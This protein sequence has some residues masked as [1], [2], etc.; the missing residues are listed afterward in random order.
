MA[1]RC[2]AALETAS[3]GGESTASP[4]V[5]ERI[6]ARA[7]LF[8]TTYVLRLHGGGG[9]DKHLRTVT[10][11]T[12]TR[13]RSGAGSLVRSVRIDD[14][15]AIRSG[16][17][18][19]N[20]SDGRHHDSDSEESSL[21]AYF[22]VERV[23]KS[24]EI[25][26]DSETETHGLEPRTSG[27][28]SGTCSGSGGVGGSA[29]GPMSRRL[30]AFLV[31][32][33]RF[34]RGYAAAAAGGNTSTLVWT[35]GTGGGTSWSPRYAHAGVVFSDG[36]VVSTG[37]VTS[38][39]VA[40]SGVHTTAAG[41]GGT[42]KPPGTALTLVSQSTFTARWSHGIARVPG[43]D[44]AFLVVAG[45]ATTLKNDAL[46]TS[47]RGANF[48]SK[49]DAVFTSGRYYTA[50]VATA[51]ATFVAYAGGAGSSTFYNEVRQSTNLGSDWTTLR[52]EGGGGGGSCVDAAMWSAR[53]K[54]AYAFMPLQNR[55][56]VAG[57][58]GSGGYN[59]DVWGSD[60]GGT[61]WS[62]LTADSDGTAT[63]GYVGASLVVAT[64]GG[65]EILVLAGGEKQTSTGV[66]RLSSVYRCLDAGMSWDVIASSGSMW[67]A[68]S[69][70]VFVYDLASRRLATMGGFLKGG[71]ANDFWS[72]D[73]SSLFI[74]LL[75]K[76]RHSAV[77][78]PAAHILFSHRSLLRTHLPLPT[79]CSPPTRTPARL[80]ARTQR[81]ATRSAAARTMSSR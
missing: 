49:T 38:G 50:L 53:L 74:P 42:A 78:P 8:I 63:S 59:Q 51:P 48:V 5:R 1:R 25:P 33:A 22:A 13:T 71:L 29:I 43:N 72:A 36:V 52:A 68:R 34:G 3:S 15:P 67:G 66:Q 9:D 69:Y 7:A 60:D 21:P 27:S 76:V 35:E 10:E 61:C 6:G 62:L 73:A 30:F 57:G 56:L 28:S 75:A 46:L 80:P 18:G 65:V 47:D 79:P 17:G 77:L 40:S 31:T 55:I 45:A 19:M 12:T 23:V 37:G 64:L 2:K 11:P 24:G 41:T 32:T 70:S 81:T 39:S 54:I 14:A 44:D 4:T 58:E 16:H 26:S 20:Q